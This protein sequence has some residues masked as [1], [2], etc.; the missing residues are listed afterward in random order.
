MCFAYTLCSLTVQDALAEV[1]AKEMKKAIA[2]EL[3]PKPI[4]L[5]VELGPGQHAGD[6]DELAALQVEE[7][8]S[9]EEDEQA[10]NAD[11]QDAEGPGSKRKDKKTKK[12]RNKEVGLET[13]QRLG[14]PND[15]DSLVT[16]S[17]LHAKSL[18]GQRDSEHWLVV[19]C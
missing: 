2:R 10:G 7:E 11:G 1:V 16:V 12:D 14:L 3:A 17:F 18:R 4:P 9:D 15:W 6:M 13:L 19:K 5:C 8:E